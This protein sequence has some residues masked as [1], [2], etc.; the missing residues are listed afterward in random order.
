M[1][2]D[3][4]PTYGVFAEWRRPYVHDTD[5]IDLEQRNKAYCKG[6][7]FNIKHDKR[8]HID[9]FLDYTACKDKPRSENDRL[10]EGIAA[11]IFYTENVPKIQTVTTMNLFI[12]GITN[13]KEISK[14]YT[15]VALQK[16]WQPSWG[17][18]QY[19]CK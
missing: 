1:A 18:F 10:F 13:Q 2:G 5:K 9:V 7:K 16:K 15:W 14:S 12:K 11:A 19:T 8:D 17:D 3:T 6:L 4:N